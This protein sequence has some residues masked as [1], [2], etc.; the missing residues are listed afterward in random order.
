[1]YDFMLFYA[2]KMAVAIAFLHENVV[3]AIQIQNYWTI[4]KIL[5]DNNI[6]AIKQQL[7]GVILC[8]FMHLK[9]PWLMG[10][11]AKTL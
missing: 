5:N 10:F 6:I 1:M 7:L 11:F 3:E 2:F 8:F 9:W 4:S